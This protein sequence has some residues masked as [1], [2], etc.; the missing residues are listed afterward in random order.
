VLRAVARDK[1]RVGDSLPFVLVSEPGDARIGCEIAQE[2]LQ[3]AVAEL[4][5]R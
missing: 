1:K 3:D 4:A 5:T 2:Q